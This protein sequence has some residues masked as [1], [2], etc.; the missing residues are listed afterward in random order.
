MAVAICGSR[1]L[2]DVLSLVDG[3]A[4]LA[5]E[6][7]RAPAEVRRFVEGDVARLL[8]LPRFVDA[9]FASLPPD[10][11]SQERPETTVLPRLRELVAVG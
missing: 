7:A 4:E 9:V 1:D 11:A 8:E 6:F 5:R 3:R 2:A 10:A